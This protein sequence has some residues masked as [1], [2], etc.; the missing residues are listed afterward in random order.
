MKNNKF[1]QSTDYLR[2]RLSVLQQGVSELPQTQEQSRW[3]TQ[4]FEELHTS[5]QQVKITQKQLTSGF[6][7]RIAELELAN[8]QLQAE[9]KKHQ[10]T[11]EALRVSEE[12]L[13]QSEARCSFLVNKAL[14]SLEVGIVLLDANFRIV[15]I[16]QALGRFFG[17]R[18]E[19]V[20]GKDN[21]QLIQEQLQYIFAEP[22]TFAAR[23]LATYETNTYV[24]HFECQVIAGDTRSERWLE[25]WSQPITSGVDA[26]GRIE[27]YTDITRRKKTKEALRRSQLLVERI[28][29]TMP[30]LLYIY[31]LVAEYNIYMNRQIFEMLGFPEQS[32]EQLGTEFFLERLYPADLSL[33]QKLSQRFTNLSDGEVIEQEFRLRHNDGSWRWFC[34]RNVVF[35]RTPD[36]LPEQIIATAQDITEHKLIE[37]ALWES[38]GRLYT[39][40]NSISDGILLV[41]LQG[42]VRFANPAVAQIFGKQPE[43]LLD[44]DFGEPMVVTETAELGISHPERGLVIGE[45][46]VA[47]TSWQGESVY[48]VALRDVT[49]RRQAAIALRES[50]ERFRQLADNIEDIFWLFSVDTEQILYVSPAYEQIMGY[51]CD[52]L[53]AAPYKWIEAVHPEDREIA[54]ADFYQQRQG[55]STT[56]E[57]RIMRPDGEI[58]WIY[59]RTFPIFNEWGEVYRLAGIA[60]DVTERKIADDQIWTSLREKEVLL[61]EIHHRVKNNLQIIASLLRLQANRLEDAHAQAILQECRNRVESMALVHESLYRSGDFSRINFTEYVR[62]LTGNLFQ[63]YNVKHDAISFKVTVE[64]EIFI[65]LAQAVP[66]GLIINE[67][68]TNALK[69]G[70]RE[71][72]VGEVF[73]NLE[74]S[75]HNQLILTVGNSGESLPQDF[76]LQTAQSMGLKLVMTL[77]KQLKGTIELERGKETI[78]KIIFTASG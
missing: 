75:T 7:R 28:A 50:E 57:Y 18:R 40:V 33:F 55:E 17:L 26:G 78:F 30:Q 31:D 45:M 39:I 10:Q 53:Q 38:E 43:D 60:E 65:S 42:I 52:N 36:G 47:E 58:R 16:N 74:A 2:D 9:V 32:P 77:V 66:C 20:L 35:T 12:G 56:K 1:A 63:I 48:V 71:H 54:T 68:V 73:V 13:L 44:Q 62:N 69:H 72:Q 76:D 41:D 24:D 46:R 61:K 67:L 19:D 23:M 15:W 3:L 59:E 21:R 11:E 51:S 34:S 37:S 25:H 64:H 4:V 5:L 27:Y 8:A 70:F 14:D 29:D 22:E 49:E 6:E